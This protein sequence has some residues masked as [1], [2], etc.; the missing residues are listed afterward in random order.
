V[1][2]PAPATGAIARA[3]CQPLLTSGRTLLS[4]QATAKKTAPSAT[5][6]AARKSQMETLYASQ[7]P[8][9]TNAT[10]PTSI[11]H[12]WINL[13]SGVFKPN[14]KQRYDSL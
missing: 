13:F 2:T 4:P 10:A 8:R 14:R 7:L 6:D 12:V 5:H 11:R 9:Y 1:R 3:R